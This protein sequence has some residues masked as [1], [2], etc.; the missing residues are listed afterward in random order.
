MRAPESGSEAQGR[1]SDVEAG[2][3]VHPARVRLALIGLVVLLL[4]GGFARTR[5]LLDSSP[6]VLHEDELIATTRGARMMESGDWNPRFFRY[7]S[8]TIYLTAVAFGTGHVIAGE[9]PSSETGELEPSYERPEIGLAPRFMLIG[10][11]LATLVF[12]GFLA[13]KAFGSP[14]LLFLAPLALLLSPRF[15]MM[16]WT[17]VNVDM[18]GAFVCS[19][20]LWLLF[21]TRH[22]DHWLTRACLPGLMTGLAVGSK[23]YLGLIGL[24]AACLLFAGDRRHRLRN[25][26]IIVAMTV[27]GFLISTPYCLLDPDF[28]VEQ[29]KREIEHYSTGHTGAES[30]A[31]LAQL[32][33]YLG[34][35]WAEFGWGPCLFGLFGIAAG[36]R[37]KPRETALLLAFPLALLLFLSTQRVHFIR[38]FLSAYAIFPVF[39]AYGTVALWRIGSERIPGDGKAQ[40]LILAILISVAFCLTA[41]LNRIRGSYSAAP[42]SRNRAVQWIEKNFAPGTIVVVADELM[43][44]SRRLAERFDVRSESLGT[45]ALAKLRAAARKKSSSVVLVLP[46]LNKSVARDDLIRR[47]SSVQERKLD[48]LFRA[49]SHRVPRAEKRLLHLGNPSLEVRL[50]TAQ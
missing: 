5:L 40:R 48:L 18:V 38:N 47:P 49:G 23:Y 4:F 31:G 45:L 37:H 42:D 46:E 29:V 17:Y 9:A 50:L 35:T 19:A 7:P 13:K 26:V 43:L 34:R 22:R 14:A 3:E 44:D 1:R 28:F 11:S 15:L 33:Y 25:V 27:I 41:P 20:A 6:Y 30:D 2:E 36:F 8:L 24:P 39:I 32:S 10:L 12:V 16:S 21:A